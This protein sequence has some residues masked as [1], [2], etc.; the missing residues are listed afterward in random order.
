LKSRLAQVPEKVFTDCGLRV[1]KG[2]TVV[3]NKIQDHPLFRQQ[4]IKIDP[5]MSFE[6]VPHAQV[7]TTG[8]PKPRTHSNQVSRDVNGLIS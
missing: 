8:V 3:V 6:I 1:G 7:T 4:Q 2:L 5:E